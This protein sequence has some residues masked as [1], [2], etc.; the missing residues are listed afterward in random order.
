[1]SILQKSK[2][3]TLLIISDVNSKIK[4]LSISNIFFRFIFVF[5]ILLL[6]AI[7]FFVYNLVAAQQKLKDKVAEIERMEEKI[8][9]EALSLE[10]LTVKTKEIE[11]KTRILESYLK[12]VEE[13]DK[14]V[15]D[16]TGKGGFDEKISVY[17]YDLNA[18]AKPEIL[19]GEVFYYVAAM[20]QEQ[21]L[22]DIDRLLD[23]LILKIPDISSKLSEDKLNMENYIYEMEHTPDIWPT[24][25]RITTLFCDGRAKVWR[26]GL[27]KGLDIAN[28]HG[29]A[30]VA[31]ASG[32][33]IFSGWHAGYGRKIMIYHGFGYTTVYAHL[34]SI[35]VNEGDE[36]IKGEK[37]GTMGSTG[38][39]TGTHLHY[40]IYVDGVPVNPLD[41][42]P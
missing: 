27:H 39:S 5:A 9:Y 42:L 10:N 31:S 34:S 32:V 6:T 8:N 15:R 26:S 35:Y 30:I 11:V 37:I 20:D 41:Y 38:R 19:S 40:E 1:M 12:Q 4:K 21:E 2:S 16:I 7:I 23:E 14:V 22:D 18:S 33:V 28:S 25:G 17:N 36:V 13:L 24:W 29:T 3:F